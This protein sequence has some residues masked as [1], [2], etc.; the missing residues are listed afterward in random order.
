MFLLQFII[1][2]YFYYFIIDFL[3]LFYYYFYFNCQ[4]WIRFKKADIIRIFQEFQ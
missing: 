1:I 3:L 2:I 4:I